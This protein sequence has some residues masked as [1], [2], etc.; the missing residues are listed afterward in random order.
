[1]DKLRFEFIWIDEWRSFC[2]ANINLSQK[3]L[4]EYSKT[5]NV[6]TIK[7]NNSYFVDF[8]SKNISAHAIIG[9]NGCGKTS[10]LTYFLSHASGDS[11]PCDGKSDFITIIEKSIGNKVVLC[12]FCS[13]DNNNRPVVDADESI[14]YQLISRRSKMNKFAPFERLRSEFGR[15]QFIYR[16]D[17]INTSNL[18]NFD[19]AYV[20]SPFNEIYELGLK[21]KRK[22]TLYSYFNESF[23]QQ[24]MFVN[25]NKEFLQKYQIKYPDYIF[26]NINHKVSFARRLKKTYK[27]IEEWFFKNHFPNFVSE[28]LFSSLQH[29]ANDKLYEYLDYYFQQFHITNKYLI[30]E[31]P[32][33][34]I[35]ECLKICNADIEFN[36]EDW[37]QLILHIEKN[38]NL[39]SEFFYQNGISSYKVPFDKLTNYDKFSKAFIKLLNLC[40][41]VSLNSNLIDVSWSL[42]SGEISLLNTFSKIV[43]SSKRSIDGYYIA[44]RNVICKN[45]I[46]LLDEAEISLHPEWQRKYV[47]SIVDLLNIHFPKTYFQIFFASHS[48]LILSDFPMQDIVLLKRDNQFAELKDKTEINETFG[49][50][51]FDI[52]NNSFFLENFIGEFSLNKITQVHK[53]LFDLY[54]MLYENKQII[55]KDNLFIEFS[56]DKQIVQMIGEP[57]LKNELEKLI[58]LIEAKMKW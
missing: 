21:Q 20:L 30:K 55:N 46:M 52:Y 40:E 9:N 4:I 47:Q 39:F 14:E 57:I 16:S 23:K 27:I 13:F 17:A 28:F 48:P 44:N 26:I 3:Y 19:G 38:I 41:S 25:E 6:I 31:N 2:D 43:Y 56:R 37:N 58:K 32:F 11:L 36:Y 1:M 18:I 22:N 35:Y 5:K 54:K 10:L 34:F 24:I 8:F 29:C 49:S 53:H 51:I 42:S 50:N 12:I 7:R 15:T 45:V 33:Q